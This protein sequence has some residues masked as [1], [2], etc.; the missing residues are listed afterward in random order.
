MSEKKLKGRLIEGA[1]YDSA[2]VDYKGISDFDAAYVYAP[3]V[4]PNFERN[5]IRAA[6]EQIEK[7]KK[8]SEQEGR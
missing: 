1:K 3:N 4:P 2:K 8:E 7:E 6:V 5:V